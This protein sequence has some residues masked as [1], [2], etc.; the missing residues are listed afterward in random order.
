MLPFL[1]IGLAATL[2]IRFERE[3]VPA[4]V[5]IGFGLLFLSFFDHCVP[6]SRQVLMLDPNRLFIQVLLVDHGG[7]VGGAIVFGRVSSCLA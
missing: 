2:L 4:R 7:Y 6:F 5:A 3:M 1:L